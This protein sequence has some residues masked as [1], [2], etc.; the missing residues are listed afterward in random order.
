MFFSRVMCIIFSFLLYSESAFI[1]SLIYR[2]PTVCGM[3]NR[4]G[5]CSREYFPV[6]GTN[7]RTYINKC[8]FCI[9]YRESRGSINL[10]RY[11][12]C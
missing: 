7:R 11:G 3:Y 6:C 12:K 5:I 4:L 10:A 8:I 1:K 9:A 2:R